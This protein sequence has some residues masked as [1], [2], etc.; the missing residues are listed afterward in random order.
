MSG[1]KR[2]AS[3][4]GRRPSA[5]KARPSAAGAV[6]S[7]VDL[8]VRYTG[9]PAALDEATAVFARLISPMSVEHFFEHHWEKA[10]LVINRSAKDSAVC[11]GLF[12]LADLEARVRRSPPLLYETHVNVC[13]VVDGRKKIMNPSR[14]S[15]GDSGD[16]DDSGGGDDG[17]GD[18]DNNNNSSHDSS[19]DGDEGAIRHEDLRRLFDEGCTL[20]VHHPQHHS[21]NVAAVLRALESFFGTFV[22]ANTYITPPGAQGLAP[23]Y[24]DVEVF[25]VQVEGEKHWRLFRNAHVLPR[26]YSADVPE[27]TFGPED[28]LAELTLRA[29]DLLYFPRGT[30]HVARSPAHTLSNHITISTYQRHAHV[31]LLERVVAARVASL[32]DAHAVLRQ[33]LGLR[34]L[35]A[36]GSVH[37]AVDPPALVADTREG[38]RELLV[39]LGQADDAELDALIAAAADDMATDFVAGRLPP[40]ARHGDGDSGDELPAAV[41]LRY[42]DATRVVL[43]GAQIEVRCALGNDPSAHLAAAAER[44]ATVVRA[45]AASVALVHALLRGSRGGRGCAVRE[46]NPKGDAALTTFLRALHAAGVLEG[47]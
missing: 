39:A 4:D 33:G 23:H 32:A 14:G 5:R 22:G 3:D 27:T 13:K 21:A 38:V 45:G 2:K 26:G 19:H 10:P 35:L 20:Q 6:G 9:G 16:D 47:C 37:G 1:R 17:G 34:S 44:P 15:G 18:D 41:R 31:D 29:G 12:T 25:I 30:Y 8:A 11:E 42:P 43:D 40:P 7:L 46:L 24:D 28:L 36:L